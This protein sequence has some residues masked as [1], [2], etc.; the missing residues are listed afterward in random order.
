MIQIIYHYLASILG[1][2]PYHAVVLWYPV[3]GTI[4][5]V[6][7]V[8][9]LNVGHWNINYFRSVSS[10]KLAFP[11]AAIFFSTGILRG[12]CAGSGSSRS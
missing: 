9:M 1:F 2:D 12:S 10:V 3:A 4:I 8:A 5:A 11:R 7:I 6:I